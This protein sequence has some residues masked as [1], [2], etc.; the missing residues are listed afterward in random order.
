MQNTIARLNTLRALLGFVLAMIPLSAGGAPA[1]DAV[2]WLVDLRDQLGEA[3]DGLAC[4][5][6]AWMGE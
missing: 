3:A 2:Y 5:L 6:D 4:L 1:V